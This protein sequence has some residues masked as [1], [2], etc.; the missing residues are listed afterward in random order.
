M[1]MAT[2]DGPASRTGASSRSGEPL[3]PPYDDLLTGYYH[4]QGHPYRSVRAHGTADWLMILTLNGQGRIEH[5]DGTETIV[6]SGDI[7]LFRPFTHHD[8]GV[9]PQAEY[10]E[11]LW[12]HFHPRAFW[13]D[14]MRWPE[15]QPGFMRLPL[16]EPIVRK[17]IITRFHETH[18]LSMGSLARKQQF[19]MNALEEVL[20]WCSTQAPRHDANPLDPRLQRARDYIQEH[21]AEKLTLDTVA[22][23]AALSTSRLTQLFR[24]Q[25]GTT[26]AQFIEA[27]RLARAEQLLAR[28]SL[29]IGMIAAEVGFENPFYFT[30]R[31]KRLTGFSPTDFR[32]RIQAGH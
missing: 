22:E 18:R 15:E 6:G 32:N 13:D 11:I 21:L 31:F 4:R 27:Q 7:I 30:Q 24:Q 16:T 20:L 2:S 3:V 1:R 29:T 10:W 19:A 8:Y 25:I 23:Q 12:T 17:K 14:W 5:S 28:T 9:A 26:P